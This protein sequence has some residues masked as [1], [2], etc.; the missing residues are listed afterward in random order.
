MWWRIRFLDL[1]FFLLLLLATSTRDEGALVGAIPT[2]NKKSEHAKSEGFKALIWHHIQ[3]RV[4]GI[5]ALLNSHPRVMI[6][7]SS[8]S[9]SIE[10]PATSP[11]LKQTPSSSPPPL[12]DS[13]PPS[14]SI[15]PPAPD[16]VPPP[17]SPQQTLPPP[18]SLQ[19]TLPPPPSQSLL[20]PP[21]Q[22]LETVPPPLISSIPVN[23]PPLPA[24]SVPAVL[25]IPPL[26]SNSNSVPSL[27]ISIPPALGSSSPLLPLPPLIAPPTFMVSPPLPSPA[28]ASPPLPSS[29]PPPIAS[30]PLPSAPP[31]TFLVL[32]PIL[33]SPPPAS[34]VPSPIVSAPPPTILPSPPP[35]LPSAP[36]LPPPPL[37]TPPPS[38]V[39][40]PPRASI[41][42]SLPPLS[43]AA[44]EVPHNISSSPA[45][46]LSSPLPS[47]PSP[48]T[49][50]SA[51]PPFQTSPPPVSSPSLEDNAPPS[52]TL[53]PPPT[54]LSSP[55]PS[56]SPPPLVASPSQAPSSRRSPPPLSG[57]PPFKSSPPTSPPSPRSL[58][59]PSLPPE[60]VSPPPKLS[61][62][63][64]QNSSATLPLSPRSA[65]PRSPT[66]KATAPA[67][68]PSLAV[69]PVASNTPAPVPSRPT[70]KAPSPVTK[71]PSPVTKAPS[72]VTKAPSPVT[73]APSPVTK[74][75][76]PVQNRP[77][78]PAPRKA[79]VVSPASAPQTPM[80]RPGPPARLPGIVAPPTKTQLAQP[81]AMVFP[82]PPNAGCDKVCSDPSV[83]TLPGTKCGCVIPMR[84]GLALEIPISSFLSL[85]SELAMEIAFGIS[86][87][88]MQVQIAA[89]N[90]FGEDFSLTETKVNLVPL[91]N[92]FRNQTAYH[93]SQMFWGH[94]VPINEAY[95]VNYTV[96][97]VI[98]PGLP[99][100]SQNVNR[101]PPSDGKF[102]DQPLGVD[103]FARR[104]RNLH[105]A[106]IAI[107][108]LSCVF[109]LILCLGV[110]WLITVR[111]RGRYKGH[112]ELTEAALESCATKRSTT[113]L[114]NSSRDSTSV[115]SSIVPYVSGSVRTFTLAEMTAATNNFNPSNVIGQGGF[116]RVYSGVLTDGTKIAVKVL[117][118]EDK[119]GDREFSAE[120]EMLS[121]LHHRNLVKLVGI[122]TDD[123]MRSLV[124][125]LIPNGSVD[126]HLHGDDKKIAPLSWEARLKIA[127]GAARGLAY[128]HEDSYPRVIHRDFKSS[129]I[130][131][132]DDF[133]PKVS[134]FGL[135][136]AASEEL[137]GHIS[138][139]VMGTFGYVAPEY[140]M[141]GHLLVKSDV[142]SYGVVLLE[143][144]SGRKPVD[145][146][147]AQG[148]ENLVTWAR[149]LLTS[150]E[151][152]DF[153]ADPDLRSS[154]APENL[155]RVAAIASMCVR[156]EVSQ[157]P[158]MGEVV[159]ALKLVCSDMDVEEGE[160]SGA[161][162]SVSSP[163]AK[164]KVTAAS[165]SRQREWDFL[166]YRSSSDFDDQQKS[167]RN[168][169]R[170]QGQG[171][172]FSASSALLRQVSASFGRHSAPE[173]LKFFNKSERFLTLP[174]GS[175]SEHGVHHYRESTVW[176]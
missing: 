128:L 5:K 165:T 40:P 23:L 30:P 81:P 138:T 7:V 14:P 154:V 119:Q 62:S 168:H 108:T 96:L 20:S 148:Q 99:L 75:P 139:R 162:N 88:Q 74:A 39:P 149:P 66:R 51:A 58:Q 84:V 43:S 41:P 110:G 9:S 158:F 42:P 127:L 59:P 146:S 125:E 72:P 86:M 150:L 69:S 104:N 56:L 19:Q 172:N 115:S 52:V 68:L 121:R 157:R 47:P 111:H 131:L 70:I 134:D 50:P 34:T 176:P 133:T 109:L 159:Q 53:G 120:V 91:G 117:I 122:C 135:A 175:A 29:A 137:T 103:I 93:I 167:L 106:F 123:D 166:S 60:V 98:Y 3:Q 124:Y 87:Q 35:P 10:G 136:K 64:I 153:L 100:A 63:P 101:I 141:T 73:K 118:R 61:P 102:P 105:P 143:L 113:L 8:P 107:I 33:S 12:L 65:P 151:G 145:M 132:E 4:G 32:P 44:P 155:A 18:P 79:P 31:P 17:P 27:P 71:A 77:Q 130:L 36:P 140:A 160:T 49:V 11:P 54:T 85:V 90:S 144:L 37:S 169:Q 55:P 95:F 16:L 126:S 21:P 45:S 94:R 1:L 173:P 28:N 13:S 38:F 89:A 174:P 26:F 6:T 67:S 92:A 112:S 57:A 171:G 24:V 142:Y 114:S 97:Y 2:C 163:E 25:Q 48:T 129:N 83:T 78:P 164:A 152:L 15:L 170:Q 161:S 80:P 147:R 156:P 76:S 116:G 82:S 46:P 22:S